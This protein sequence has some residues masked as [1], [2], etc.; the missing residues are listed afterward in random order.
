MPGNPQAKI[1]R[2]TDL[3]EWHRELSS[4]FDRLL[5]SCYRFNG[6]ASTGDARRDAWANA[7]RCVVMTGAALTELE[8]VLRSDAIQR[9]KPRGEPSTYVKVESAETEEADVSGLRL[10][11][12]IG[13]GH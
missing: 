12:Q 9:A 6:V 13:S 8:S 3:A 2:V 1:K 7:D 10:P 4:D 5:P 11:T